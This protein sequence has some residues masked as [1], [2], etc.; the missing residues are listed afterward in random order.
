MLCFWFCFRFEPGNNS[1]KKLC[2]L[3][4]GVLVIADI[5]KWVSLCLERELAADKLFHRDTI[6]PLAGARM[7]PR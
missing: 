5:W 4:F 3:K 7:Q 1:G 6:R 2:V